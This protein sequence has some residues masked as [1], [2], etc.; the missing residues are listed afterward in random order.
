MDRLTAPELHLLVVED[1][2][3]IQALL[4]ELLS[5]EGYLVSCASTLEETLALVEEQ[6]F[7]GILTDLVDGRSATPL[8]SAKIIQ[9]RVLPTPVGIMTAW[10]VAPEEVVRQRLAF[11]VEKPFDTEELL[12]RIAISL[13]RPLTCEQQRQAEVIER[14]S[15]AFNARDLEALLACYTDD[16]VYYPPSR[17]FAAHKLYGKAAYR[18]YLERVFQRVPLLHVEDVLF[19]GR[20]KGLASRYHQTWTTPDGS[21]QQ[22]TC[23]TLHHFRGEFICQVGARANPQRIQQLLGVGAR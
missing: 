13:H 15:A 14:V 21:L 19:Y 16:L 1:D 7:H 9:Q 2:L 5:D 4:R 11:L 12:A 18:D 8:A 23:T 20:P 3:A 6:T 10:K 22:Q 17:V